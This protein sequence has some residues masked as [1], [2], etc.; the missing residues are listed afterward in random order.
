MHAP[1]KYWPF[2]GIILRRL[3]PGDCFGR[4][5]VSDAVDPKPKLMGLFS[6][7]LTLCTTALQG[8]MRELQLTSHSKRLKRRG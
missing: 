1:E 3:A 4:G 2:T 7:S 8:Q 5:A 6:E